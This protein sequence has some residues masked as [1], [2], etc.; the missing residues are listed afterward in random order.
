MEGG[1]TLPQN[2]DFCDFGHNFRVGGAGRDP[3]M[4][5]SNHR[6]TYS[7][8]PMVSLLHTAIYALEALGRI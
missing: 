3:Y 1:A 2:Q 8:L 6:Y 4:Q 7:S 5:L